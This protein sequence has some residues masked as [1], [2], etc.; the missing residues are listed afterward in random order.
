[1]KKVLA[2]NAGS[3]TLKFKLFAMPDEL[4][5][6]EGKVD[7]IGTP[8]ADFTII[9]DGQKLKKKVEAPTAREAVQFV[10]D[11]LVKEGIIAS[12]DEIHGVGH[13][14]VHG[15]EYFKDSTPINGEVIEK[16]DELSELAPLHNP[17]NLAGINAFQEVLPNVTNVAVFDT[18][19]HQQMPEQSYL[20]GVPMEWYK[21]YR[22]R[23]YGFHGISHKFVSTRVQQLINKKDAKVIVCH[24][25]SGA[26]ICA[27]DGD[28]SIDTT[29]GFGPL[30]GLIMGTR[31]GDI[32]VTIIS[33]IMKKTG[34]SLEEIEFDLNNKSGFLGIS[35]LSN[36]SR[37]IEDGIK[38]GHPGCRLAQDIFNRRV[39]NYIAAYHV[40]LQG[41]D[42]IAFTAGIGEMSP[43]TREE[44][45]R[46]L[47]VLGFKLDDKLNDVYG[48]ER[49]ISAKG[50]KI[51]IF[52]IPTNEEIM[53][54]RDVMRFL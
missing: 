48:K 23:K 30:A 43:Q 24:L 14:V 2:I 25:G 21:K 9:V 38:N 51:P 1:M 41:A 39:I 13:R 10:L 11:A 52:V 32:D 20:Y 35:E 15:G 18:S 6:T 47:E 28:H 16:I 49:C 8:D 54:A 53:I 36:D 50:S 4:V 42:A 45:I 12:I 17:A 46:E 31:C 22:I 19:F 26:S 3:S 29:M 27:V 37:D 7:R 40:L 5:L 33:Y 44:V 34:K